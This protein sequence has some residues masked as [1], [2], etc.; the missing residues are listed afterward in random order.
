MVCQPC[1]TDFQKHNLLVAILLNTWGAVLT[2]KN[3]GYSFFLGK[4]ASRAFV[5]GEA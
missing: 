2:G 3:G 5:T 1:M 4:D